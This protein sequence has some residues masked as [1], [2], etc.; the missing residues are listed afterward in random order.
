MDFYPDQILPWTLKGIKTPWRINYMET[1]AKAIRW[2]F[3]KY[4]QIPGD[5]IPEYATCPLFLNVGFSGIL[6]Q[7]KFGFGSSPFAA[8]DN[9]YPGL[10]SPSDFKRGRITQKIR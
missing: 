7:K 8:V 6:T 2:L 4:L 3:E 1:A 5:E 9:A 10:F